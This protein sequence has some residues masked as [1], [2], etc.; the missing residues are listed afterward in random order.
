MKPLAEALR[1]KN[2]QDVVGHREHLSPGLPL[3]DAIANDQIFSCLFYAPPGVGKTT[4]SSVIR[5]STK[6]RWI[7]MSAI[8][9]GV[10]DLKAALEE[11][12]FWKQKEG[13]GSILFVDEIHHFNKSQQDILLGAIERGDIIFIAATTENPAYEVNAA[14]LSRLRV[15]RFERLKSEDILFLL[16][17]AKDYLNLEDVPETALAYI[18]EKSQGDARIALGVFELAQPKFSMPQIGALFKDQG[19]SHD[20]RGDLHYQVISAFIKSMR[21]GETDAALYYL[22]RLWEA[23]EDPLFIARRMVI[24]ASEDIGNA[25]IRALAVANA[26]KNACEFVGRP[27]CYYALSQGVIFL[28]DA[29]KSR[30]AGDRFEKARKLVHEKGASKVPD[31]LV[32]GVTALDRSLGRGRKKRDG[33]SYISEDR[34]VDNEA[35]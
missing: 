7:G 29:K 10:K 34:L 4:L 27:E 33:E 32:N 12:V 20:K 35:S 6:N 2:L 14:L 24:F 19:F 22:A 25:D 16:L 9:S 17:R 18:A 21:A 13:K 15:F 5:H 30:E 28:S 26:V 31:F 11:A 3:Y 23:G 8:A 1:P